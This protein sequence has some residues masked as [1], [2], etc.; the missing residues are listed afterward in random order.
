MWRWNK[1]SFCCRTNLR[2]MNLFISKNSQRNSVEFLAQRKAIYF[3]VQV[4]LIFWVRLCS[5]TSLQRASLHH[6]ILKNIDN[7]Y[8]INTHNFTEKYKDSV[9]NNNCSY[10]P[11]GFDLTNNFPGIYSRPYC[12]VWYSMHP[13]QTKI[14]M[15][16]CA[17]EGSHCSPM[18]PAP[19]KNRTLLCKLDVLL[20]L[21][22]TH[23]DSN[24]WW[25]TNYV[26][27]KS[28]MR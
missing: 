15:I 4:S 26:R 24:E 18:F 20:L 19:T 2:R 12:F 11:N 17:E 13:A 14:R 23:H 9:D 16:H 5:H 28:E 3:E 21:V 8:I 1:L 25:L 22:S 10:V 27:R 7:K 6:F